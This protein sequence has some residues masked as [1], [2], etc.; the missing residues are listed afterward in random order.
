MSLTRCEMCHLEL[1]EPMD[2]ITA[3]TDALSARDHLLEQT[4]NELRLVRLCL[5]EN[6]IKSAEARISID[7]LNDALKSARDSLVEALGLLDQWASYADEYYKKKWNFEGD[8]AK[9]AEAINAASAA[10]NGASAGR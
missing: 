9:L 8:K 2:C 3:L 6:E 10:L 7:L 4:R 1:H 5:D